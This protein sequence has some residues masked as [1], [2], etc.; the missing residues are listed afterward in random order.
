MELFKTVQ[1]MQ[2]QLKE[3]HDTALQLAAEK[4]DRQAHMNVKN[5]SIT[6]T[7]S[8]CEQF[9]SYLIDTYFITSIN[10]SSISHELITKY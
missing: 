8:N 1:D 9:N 5:F 6:T 4:E 10:E 7:Q 3:V 2:A